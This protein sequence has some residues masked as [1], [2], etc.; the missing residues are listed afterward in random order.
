MIERPFS[1]AAMGGLTEGV[2]KYIEFLRTELLQTMIMTGTPSLRQLPPD[3][4]HK[5]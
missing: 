5:N 2:A 1:I 3:L 4:L